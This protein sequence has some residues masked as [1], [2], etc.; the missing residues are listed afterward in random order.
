MKS[1]FSFISFSFLLVGCSTALTDSGK[2]V[3]LMKSDPPSECTEVGGVDGRSGSEDTA[4]NDMRNKAAE[5]GA[6]YVRYES[7]GYPNFGWGRTVNG[8]A[9]KCPRK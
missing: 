2:R 6:N 1:I 9:Y 5:L 7:T 8:T 4:K 3:Q